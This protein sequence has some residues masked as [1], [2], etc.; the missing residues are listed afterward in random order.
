[1]LVGAPR[2]LSKSKM[3][4]DKMSKNTDLP[5]RRG[6]VVSSLPASE[7]IGATGREIE[8]PQGLGW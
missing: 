5:C 2:F 1:V 4:N 8:S 7:E 6:L 3:S